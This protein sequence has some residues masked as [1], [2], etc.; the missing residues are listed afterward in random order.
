[1]WKWREDSMF[2]AAL[3]GSM[4]YFS[5]QFQLNLMK[6]SPARLHEGLWGLHPVDEGLTGSA[7][8]LFMR[9]SKKSRVNKPCEVETYKWGKGWTMK[10]VIVAAVSLNRVCMA[11]TL[12]ICK[13]RA[14]THPQ[15]RTGIFIQA[16]ELCSAKSLLSDLVVL[17]SWN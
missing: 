12:R 5:P 8:L 16:Y 1:M 13:T 11:L 10:P 2:P 7:T 15:A 4:N 6:A 14:C 9:L 17:R 3:C